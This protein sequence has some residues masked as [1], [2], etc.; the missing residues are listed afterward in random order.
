MTQLDD[1]RRSLL[2]RAAGVALIAGS[3]FA[4][5][6]LHAADFPVPGKPI[7]VIVAFTA[8]AGADGQARAV[9]QE[10]GRI[11]G[12][13]VM[14]ENKPG[15][16]TLLAASEVMKSAP[17]G[18]TIFYS[19]SSTMAQNPHTLK[20]ATYNPA[21]DFTPISMGGKGPLVLIAS[22]KLP[23]KNVT[24]LVA[25]AKANPQQMSYG[26]FGAGTSS[27]IFGEVFAKRIGVEMPH[28]PYKGGAEMNA[29][30][31]EGRLPMAFDA[32]PSAII[33][34]S[35]GKARILAVAA[36]T[37]SPFLPDVPTLAEQGIPGI[38]LASFLGWFGPARMPP[39]VV[40]RL[41]D[42]LAQA[43]ATPTVQSLYNRGAYTAESSTPQAL[44]AEV[45]SAYDAWGLLVKQSGLSKQ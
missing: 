8:G 44:A 39:E 14:V 42:A 13:T 32:A 22:S 7:R 36:P 16:G 43:I 40:S 45:K 10:L 23:V 21:T 33:N 9:A 28:I 17:D 4:A 29:E 27:H 30:L 2:L 41:H 18:Y 12:T 26:S 24:E 11:L 20:A 19:A 34:S 3:P 15:A 37:R 25:W 38:D 31:A 6:A 5:T 35:S 1:R